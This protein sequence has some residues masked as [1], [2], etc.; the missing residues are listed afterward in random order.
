MKAAL[1]RTAIAHMV[2]QNAVL[3]C[4]EKSMAIIAN[5][6]ISLWRSAAKNG[7]HRCYLKAIVRITPLR[8]GWNN[9][10]FQ[11]CS[12]TALSSWTTHLSTTN[13]RWKCCSKPQD[14]PCYRCQNTRQTSTPSSN[15]S[16]YSNDKG[17]SQ[18]IRSKH[19]LCLIVNWID[20][21]RSCARYD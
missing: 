19:Y 21:K 8:R 3:K 2:G 10:W 14:T 15:P 12:Q 17:N 5:A 1:R 13:H 7:L 16:P 6:P 18:I 11:S 9:A 4:M 20:Y